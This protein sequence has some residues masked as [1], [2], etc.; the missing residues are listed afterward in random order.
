MLYNGSYII[1]EWIDVDSDSPLAE[2]RLDD[3]LILKIFFLVETSGDVEWHLRTEVVLTGVPLLVVERVVVGCEQGEVAFGRIIVKQW[4]L[5]NVIPIVYCN[6]TA[7]DWRV[8][9]LLLI[10]VEAARSDYFR[11]WCYDNSKG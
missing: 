10:T 2:K 8:E 1:F 5:I 6:N 4:K 3:L 9:A 7:Y 11:I